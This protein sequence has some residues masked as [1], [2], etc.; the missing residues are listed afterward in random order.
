[1]PEL[2]LTASADEDF[3]PAARRRVLLVCDWFLRYVVPFAEAL[4]RDGVEVAVLC[5]DHAYEFE[6]NH[7]ERQALLDRLLRAGVVVIEMSGRNTS[8]SRRAW[9]AAAEARGWHADLVHAQSEI[10]DPRM[11]LAVGR[12]PL[13]LMVHDP[14]PHLGAKAHALHHRVLQ[15]LWRRRADLVLVHGERLRHAVR[16]GRSVRVLPHGMTPRSSAMPAP[17]ERAILL[18][19][20]LEYYKGVR[21]LLEAMALVWEERAEVR[22]IIAGKGPEACEIRQDPRIDLIGRYIPEEDLDELFA[23]ASVVVLP[24]LDASQSGVGLL[25]LG[26]GI[27]LV[28]TDVGDLPDLVADESCVARRGDAVSLAD[29]LLAHLDHDDAFRAAVLDRARASF[30]WDAV[31]VRARGLYDE[32]LTTHS[33]NR[34]TRRGAGS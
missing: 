3:D 28:V 17:A 6:Q 16:P 9:S 22:L 32:L 23:R 30:G 34:R 20:R 7:A 5:R 24:Y 29:A 25:A 33:E 27:P 11:L 15:A 8:F 2:A 1:M 10:L 13:V 31:A 26:R 21:L 19:G 12:S 18:F 4:R 14:R